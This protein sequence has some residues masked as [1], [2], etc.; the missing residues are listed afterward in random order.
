MLLY[1]FVKLSLKN[2]ENT[3]Q[4]SLVKKKPLIRK[5]F[6]VALVVVVIFSLMLIPYQRPSRM[7][8]CR[9]YGYGPEKSTPLLTLISWSREKIECLRKKTVRNIDFGMQ[10]GESSNQNEEYECYKKCQ[11]EKASSTDD[12]N[13]ASSGLKPISLSDTECMEKCSYVM[14]DEKPVIYLYPSYPQNVKVKLEYDGEIIVDYPKYDYTIKGW[15]VTAYPD[16]RIIDRKDG[17]EYSYLFWEGRPSEETD[18]DMAKGFV[19][20]GEDTRVF[21]QEILS[22]IG[23]TPREYNEFIVY[24][25][26]RMKKNKYNLI[27]FAGKEYTDRAQ[28]SITPKPESVLRVFMV[29]KKLDEKI[30]VEPQVIKPFVR[31]GF[32]VVEWGGTEIN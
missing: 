27:T 32:T 13:I 10:T 12:Q 15:E 30:E 14:T 11:Q 2:M 8:L 4:K 24:W 6:I 16:G 7:A 1:R 25:Y 17:K 5:R 3:K 29:Y 19:V 21:L 28:L 23:M 26:P 9:V 20:K 31:K 22:Q 18:W